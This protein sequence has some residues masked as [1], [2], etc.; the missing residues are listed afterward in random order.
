MDCTALYFDA[1]VF[2]VAK[3]YFLADIF[4]RQIKPA[5]E[6]DF[7]VDYEHFSMVATVLVDSPKWHYA[8]ERN[9]F[10]ILVQTF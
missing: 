8:V 3:P 7:V 1:R 6:R 4:V 9:R 5:R 2:P 10:D